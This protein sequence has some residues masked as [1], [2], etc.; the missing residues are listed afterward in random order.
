MFANVCT[1]IYL[2]MCLYN[3][4]MEANSSLLLIACL[5]ACM[6]TSAHTNARIERPKVIF[7]SHLSALHTVMY[8]ITCRTLADLA[9]FPLR[10][11]TR[12]IDCHT[13]T[14]PSWPPLGRTQLKLRKKWTT[15]TCDVKCR[16]TVTIRVGLVRHCHHSCGF[17]A[18]VNY[19][20]RLI[21][22]HMRVCIQVQLIQVL[23]HCVPCHHQ[24]QLPSITGNSNQPL[25]N[26][27]KLTIY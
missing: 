17:W 21:Y 27:Y 20:L 16:D 10:W 2:Y 18:F 14:T 15:L 9:P 23:I 11:M 6:F 24:I 26:T 12:M 5:L 1:H 19:Q 25:L 8:S 13:H 7:L 22:I 4:P 3:D